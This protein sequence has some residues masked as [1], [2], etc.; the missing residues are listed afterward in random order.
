MEVS[1]HSFLF[2]HAGAS[3]TAALVWPQGIWSASVTSSFT[4]EKALFITSCRACVQA[5]I[6]KPQSFK[7]KCGSA[8]IKFKKKRTSQLK[9]SSKDL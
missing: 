5:G 6:I 7:V 9:S 4:Q 8:C 3:D 1:P 2:G